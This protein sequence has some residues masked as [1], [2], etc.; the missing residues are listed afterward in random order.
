MTLAA[1]VAMLA[2]A[3][4]AQ[5]LTGAEVEPLLYP[6]TGSAVEIV[7]QPFLPADQAQMLQTV[8]AA[9]AYYGAI[10]V[11]PDEGMMVEATVAAA[12]H[13]ST[14]AASIAALAGCDAKRKGAAPCV[15]VA[16]IRP[17][18]WQARAFQLSSGATAGFLDNYAGTRRARA[19]AISP[20]TGHW[21]MGKGGDAAAKAVKDCVAKAA[22]APVGDCAVVVAD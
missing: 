12:N 7:P 10:A 13:H 2:T 5:D 19:F 1:M 18:G 15:I 6:A 4:P 11:S 9:Q 3:A 20:A 17:A 22:G 14:E 21:G 16:L 8:G